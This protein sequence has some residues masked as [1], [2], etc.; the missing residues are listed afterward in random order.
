MRLTRG[1]APAVDEFI[2]AHREWTVLEHHTQHPGLTVMVRHVINLPGIMVWV[3]FLHAAA[4][5]LE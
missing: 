1:F 4:R 2:V 3:T 5:L